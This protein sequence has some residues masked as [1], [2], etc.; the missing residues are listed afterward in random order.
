MLLTSLVIAGAIALA[1]T[2][3]LL[4]AIRSRYIRSRLQFS[5]WLLITFLLLEAVISQGIGDIELLATIARLLFVLAVLNL[6]I[7]LLVNRWREDRPSER[8]PRLCR[9]SP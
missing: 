3:A 2:L 9:T 1:I 4:I 7:S 6:A 8:F 5:L